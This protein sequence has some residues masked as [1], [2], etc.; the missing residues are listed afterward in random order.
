MG[1]RWLLAA[2][3]THKSCTYCISLGFVVLLH[4]PRFR[5]VTCSVTDYYTAKCKTNLDPQ[6]RAAVIEQ[7]DTR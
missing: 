4:S 6:H 3:R 7:Q 2:L 1:S 5:M